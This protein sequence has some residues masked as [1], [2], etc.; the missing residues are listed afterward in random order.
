MENGPFSYFPILKL[1]FIRD[2]PVPCLIT[3][4]WSYGWSYP[5]QIWPRFVTILGCLHPDTRS[6]AKWRK[7]FKGAISGWWWL[8]HVL[9]FHIL[10]ILPTDWYVFHGWNH[11]Y[12]THHFAAGRLHE[13]RTMSLPQGKHQ[14][15]SEPQKHTIRV[16]E[17]WK[18]DIEDIWYLLVYICIYIYIFITQ[19]CF[20]VLEVCQK[21]GK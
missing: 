1:L 11:H 20:F 17:V 14:Q 6:P 15:K 2:F 21:K 7:L 9:F 3:D 5:H 19:I 16:L 10:G 4:V 12:S 18:R 8:E 13:S